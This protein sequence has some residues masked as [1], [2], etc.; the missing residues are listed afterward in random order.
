MLK[1]NSKRLSISR[2]VRLVK[3]DWLGQTL[4][5]TFW[6]ASIFAYGITSLGDYLQ[7]AAASAWLI[8]NIA[9]LMNHQDN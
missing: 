9:I 7:L 8:A 1:G 5:S 3:I 6:M 2:L 4:A